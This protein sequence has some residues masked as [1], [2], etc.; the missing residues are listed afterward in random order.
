MHIVRVILSILVG[1]I[2]GSLVN[3]SLV[4][5]SGHVIPPPPGADM[6]TAEGLKAS[7][8]LLEPKHFLFPFLAHALG[9][10]V[11]SFIATKISRSVSWVPAMT[12]GA[13]F[14]LGGVMS[15]RMIPAPTWFATTDLILAYF[16]FAWAGW[17]LAKKKSLSTV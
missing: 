17:M 5:L 14:F 8:H 6:T 1:L 11:G 15:V 10:L 2:I 13:F 4:M 16:P 9:T 3:M 7:I 12:V